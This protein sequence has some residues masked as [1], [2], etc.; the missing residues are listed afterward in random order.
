VS[1]TDNMSLGTGLVTG[2]MRLI[3]DPSYN[4]HGQICIRQDNPLPVTVLGVIPEVVVG[5]R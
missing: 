5:D 3:I 4:V 2:D 1:S